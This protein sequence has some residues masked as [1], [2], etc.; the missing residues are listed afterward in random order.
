[1]ATLYG[2]EGAECRAQNRTVVGDG[3]DDGPPRRSWP[4]AR[5]DRRSVEASQLP[6]SEGSSAPIVIPEPENRTAPDGP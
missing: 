2:K 1:M 4:Q 5:G 6:E 3:R